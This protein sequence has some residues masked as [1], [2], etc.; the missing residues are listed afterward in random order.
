MKITLT[1]WHYLI[2]L[3]VGI[4]LSLWLSSTI[5]LYFAN[6]NYHQ[7]TPFTVFEYG[8]YYGHDN[9]TRFWLTL[10]V[11]FGFA[12][13][14]LLMAAKFKTKKL[15]LYGEARFASEK[16]IKQTGLLGNK[17]IV[18]GKQCQ[19]FNQRYLQFGGQQHVLMSAPTRSGK[20]VGV[21]IPN[22]LS[23]QDSVVVLDIKQENW[24]ITAGFRQ[25]HG[26][27]CYLLNLAPRDYRSHRWNP[28]H[29]ISNDPSFR[30]NDIQKIGQ[31]LFPN[32]DNESPVWQASSRSLWLGLVL[33]LI[34]TPPLP[35]TM[36]EVLRLLTQGDE[37]L[38]EQITQRMESNTHLSAQCFLS[39]KE[40]LDTP[41]RTRGSIRKSFTSALELFYNPVIDAVTASND[42][43]LRELR[44][45][46]ISIYVGVTPDDLTRL[47]PLINLFFQQLIDLN[48]RELPE[49]NP[50]LKHQVLLLLDE[51]AAIGKI[52]ILSR[53]ISYVAGYGLRLLTIIQSPSQL[54]EIYGHDG[55]ETLIE[56]HALQIVFA[57]KNPK[58]AREISETLGNTTINNRSRSKQLSGKGGKSENISDHQRALLL[59]QEIIQ[60]GQDR[61]LLLV[62]N[63]PPIKCN[64]IRW[65]QD[66][67]LMK[68]GNQNGKLLWK[69]PVISEVK[70]KT[71]PVTQFTAK[72]KQ[73]GD[74]ACSPDTASMSFNHQSQEEVELTDIELD[75]LVDAFSQQVVRGKE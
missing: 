48:T 30:I 75:D 3:A 1:K 59:P 39:L 69:T 45:Q 27:Q 70:P 50:S 10:S 73:E 5:Y 47:A 25:S 44:K 64:K 68:R 51:F 58:V 32:I 33:Y 57:P 52:S 38:A 14:S 41:E 22:L 24:N 42:F 49:Q 4:L 18:V 11:V 26:Q 13:F 71:V 2:L 23:W 66:G 7:A 19:M 67:F 31:M 56:N 16:D 54:R 55:A 17:G 72:A 62:E 34:E 28:L 29:Y 36:G 53:G 61:A 9:K 65:Y 6:L 37:H 20:G 35:V 46:K 63:C 43:D 74:D 8:Y 60:L 15:P 21:V 40:Y 12:P